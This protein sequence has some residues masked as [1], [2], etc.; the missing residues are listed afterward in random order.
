MSDFS[1]AP[2]QFSY[3]DVNAL[4]SLKH[5][6]DGL[7]KVAAQ[8]ESL[9]IDIWLKQM[10]AANA[11]LGG[12]SYLTSDAVET[13]QEMLDH[14]LAVHLGENGGFGLAKMITQQLASKGDAGP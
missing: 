8:F 1:V 11:N 7:E 9:F 4:A 2:T 12:D 3:S 14:Q 5:A 6:P 10:R 13:Q